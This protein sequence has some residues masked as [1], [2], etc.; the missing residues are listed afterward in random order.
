MALNSLIFDTVL[1]LSYAN[2]LAYEN[3]TEGGEVLVPIGYLYK[4][5]K[6]LIKFLRL[7]MIK[8]YNIGKLSGKIQEPIKKLENY[9]K[10]N[11]NKITS[12]DERDPINIE[13]KKMLNEFHQ[14]L[15]ITKNLLKKD[16]SELNELADE[17]NNYVFYIDHSRSL[18]KELDDSSKF[19]G[20]T[21]D[22]LAIQ[23]ADMEISKRSKLIAES[24]KSA[25]SLKRAKSVKITKT[26]KTIKNAN[27]LPKKT[28]FTL[29]VGGALSKRYP[30]PGEFLLR[31]KKI[32]LDKDIEV[33]YE[34]LELD[35]M[36][37]EKKQ[38]PNKVFIN[39]INE[40]WKKEV[41]LS[42]CLDG[43]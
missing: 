9:I 18:F 25:K 3:L 15:F 41:S 28:A 36:K 13:Y 6:Y 40:M 1:M 39:K 2:Y 32:N 43:K 10:L 27:S 42:K 8:K 37:E 19:K 7:F 31:I 24:A 26:I 11:L 38:V 35:T 20:T 30:K 34:D 14:G 17:F 16:Y 33:D 12:M 22:S 5:W 23:F 29:K 4:Y 21:I